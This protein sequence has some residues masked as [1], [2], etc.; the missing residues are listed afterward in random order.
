MSQRPKCDGFIT[1]D[2]IEYL[3]EIFTAYDGYVEDFS[4]YRLSDDGSKILISEEEHEDFSEEVQQH[5]NE[6]SER[7][8]DDDVI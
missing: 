5:Y 1:R 7:R 6:W 2:G 3:Y 8:F 4:V